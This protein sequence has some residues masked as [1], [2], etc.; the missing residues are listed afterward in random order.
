[1]AGEVSCFSATM[2]SFRPTD[3]LKAG[4]YLNFFGALLS[5][6][7]KLPPIYCNLSCFLRLE[8]NV[9][10]IQ[11]TASAVVVPATDAQFSRWNFE[12]NFCQII[13]QIEDLTEK[14]YRASSERT[15]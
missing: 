11:F 10:C 12:V 6:K 5:P 15:A 9:P 8:V 14:A 1:M 7:Q 4:L 13:L 3:L 2:L